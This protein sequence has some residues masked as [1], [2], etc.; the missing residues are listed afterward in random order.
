MGKEFDYTVFS[1]WSLE[2][3]DKNSSEWFWWGKTH[4]E[5]NK[6]DGWRSFLEDT[7]EDTEPQTKP[8]KSTKL[9]SKKS[10]AQRGSKKVGK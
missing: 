9:K 3:F 10:Q 2:E 5:D 4:S 7:S 1:K 8:K 6:D